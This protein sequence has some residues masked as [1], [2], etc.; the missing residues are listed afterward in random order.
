MLHV[1]SV[2]LEAWSGRY[3]P[4][5]TACVLVASSTALALSAEAPVFFTPPSTGPFLTK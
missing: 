4:L 5:I 3:S 2:M 1:R